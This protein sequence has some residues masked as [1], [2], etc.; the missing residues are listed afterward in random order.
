[1]RSLRAFL[2]VLLLAFLAAPPA[3]AQG[4]L[5]KLKDKAKDKI[6]Q[7]SDN[8]AQSIVDKADAA[9]VCAATDQ[10]CIS[11]AKA[12]GKPV[13]VTGADGKPLSGAD[14]AKAVNGA[15]AA[16]ADPP[17]KGVW[18][19]YDFV[20]GDR[21]IWTEDFSEDQVGDFPS[22]LQ[23]VDGNFEV[24]TVDGHN[25]LHTTTGGTVV[26]I[27]PEKL[28]Q[29]FTLEVDYWAPG[30]GNPLHFQTTD[31][32]ERADFGCYHDEAWVH[33]GVGGGSSSKSL[34]H[35]P[36]NVFVTCRFMVDGKYI[37]GFINSERLANVP[38]ADLV[39]GDSLIIHLPG[40]DD[41]QVLVS[42]FRL[43]EGG[44]PMYQALM[45]SGRVSTHGILFASGSDQIAGES[46]PTLK[47]IGTM[48]QQ[49]PDLK[50]L[51][52]GHTDDQ[53]TAAGNQALSD[54]RA[55]AVK[56]YL[57]ANYGIGADRLTTRGYG[58]TRPVA[59]NG[60]PEGRQTNRRVELVKE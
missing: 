38:N 37:K 18:L 35:E 43:A 39:R 9:V 3:A 16:P 10:Q 40:T 54:K 7:H 59:S 15:G 14:S 58:Q 57:V 23:L 22:R 4:F 26:A 34:A 44:K 47:E 13:Q 27:L 36:Q 24:V 49:H 42:N 25:W 32:G 52:E 6:D 53:G 21:T 31:D 55:A 41:G 33:G 2:P 51:I 48:L 19:N 46:T 45:Q 28:P 20:P 1:M 11:N 8:A 56:A 17:G 30:L 12:A 5:S 29:R 60:T 50:V